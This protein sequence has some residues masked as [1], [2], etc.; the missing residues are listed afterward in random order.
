MTG[1]AKVVA[2]DTAYLL[3]NG[4]L[5]DY[6][7][8]GTIVSILDAITGTSGSRYLVVK[9]RNHLGVMTRLPFQFFSMPN[10]SVGLPLI[11]LTKEANIWKKNMAD[12][13][14]N[15]MTRKTSSS[16]THWMLSAGDLNWE[17]IYDIVRNSLYADYPHMAEIE[18]DLLR[19]IRKNGLITLFDENQITEWATGES[20]SPVVV[21]AMHTL[22]DINFDGI[23]DWSNWLDATGIPDPDDQDW[24]II[25]YNRS[26]YTQVKWE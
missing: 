16:G 12:D 15:H 3:S 25:Y 19:K 22:F 18:A 5:A 7:T 10:P 11:D 14:E 4:Y 13:L 20:G 6:R 8:G 9:H 23:V 26:K 17:S 21:N 1:G 24:E 2:I